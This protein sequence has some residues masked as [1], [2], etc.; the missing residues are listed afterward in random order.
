MRPRTPLGVILLFSS[1]AFLLL[2]QTWFLRDLR[3]DTALPQTRPLAEFP[4]TAGH[5][6]SS[7]FVTLSRESLRSL[8]ADEILSRN[9]RDDKTGFTL[10][11]LIA[12]YRT[13]LHLNQHYDFEEYLS[14]DGWGQLRSNVVQ[15]PQK[16]NTTASI[17]YDLVLRGRERRLILRWFQTKQR[18]LADGEGLHFY[19]A[20]NAIFGRRTDLARVQIVW[21]N[22]VDSSKQANQDAFE[23]AQQ[24]ITSIEATL[25]SS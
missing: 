4:A 3:S 6:R 7:G 13:Q 23:F 22:F 1:A 18:I 24:I 2:L 20:L 21:P 8:N 11:L 15:L 9:Y 5:W 10:N 19:R 16:S 25:F 17:R 14:D 12:Y